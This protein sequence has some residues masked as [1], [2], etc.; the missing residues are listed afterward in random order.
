MTA[1]A[2]T[3]RATV[4]AYCAA[5]TAGDRAAYVG[6]FAEDAWLEDPVG[7]PQIKGHEAIGGFFEQ[8]SSM[9]ESIELRLTGPVRVAAGE[10]AFPMQARPSIG[11]ATFC[12]DIIDVMTF[13]DA[14][15]ITTM[16]A[17]W[18]PAEMRPADDA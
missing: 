11:G 6:L 7:S 1:D 12:V 9:A 13:D 4:E 17:F 8:S 5:F 16:R 3:I 14:G 10:A 18:D 15:K 2:A